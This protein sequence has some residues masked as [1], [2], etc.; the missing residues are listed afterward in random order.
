MKPVRPGFGSRE[1]VGGGFTLIEL[2]TVIAIIGVLAAILIPT[3]GGARN[4]ALRAQTK[5]R[6]TQWA[7]AME[8]FRQEY[9]YLPAVGAGPRLDSAA[10]LAALTGRD[11]RGQPL[12]GAALNGNTKAIVFYTA[13]ENELV[14]GEAGASLA[15]LVDAFGNSEIVVLADNDG[16]GVIAGAELVNVAVR[17]GNSQSGFG[18][19]VT[20]RPEDFPA[21]GI[22]A[23]VALYSAG[24]GA[25]PEDIIYSW[26]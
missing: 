5:V 7:S 10:F 1:K 8:Q 18:P 26:R 19:A 22:R 23:S 25:N 16:D 3:L 12:S 17:T 2:L 13:A 9:G 20:P 4:S 6:F 11:Q 14:R 21:A 24:R 15:E